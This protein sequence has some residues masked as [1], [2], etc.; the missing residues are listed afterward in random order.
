M[1]FDSHSDSHSR[2]IEALVSSGTVEHRTWGV[3]AVNDIPG[4][5]GLTQA[6]FDELLRLRRAIGEQRATVIERDTLTVH[7]RT[8]SPAAE[9]PYFPEA[10]RDVLEALRAAV[11]H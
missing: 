6:E 4:V 8:H 10:W 9:R 11:R 7:L 2:R 3:A 5:T 1:G